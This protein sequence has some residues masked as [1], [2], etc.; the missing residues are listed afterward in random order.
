[1]PEAETKGRL[2]ENILYFCA[3]LR[4]AGIKVGTAQV[5]DCIKAVE[6]VGF[7]SRTDF[8]FTLRACLITRPDQLVLFQQVFTMFWRDPEFLERMMTSMLP[9]LQVETIDRPPPPGETRA[10]EALLPDP[11]PQRA[12]K[13]TGALEIEAQFSFSATERLKQMDFEQMTRA[14]AQEAKKAIA[15]MRLPLPN[16]TGRRFLVA[17]YGRKI[18]PRAA[19]RRARRTGGEVLHLPRQT[20]RPKRPDLVVLCDISGSMS[21]YSRMMMHFLHTLA[22]HQDAGWARLHAFTFGTRL[23]NISRYLGGK[24]P[25][26]AL[27]EIGHQVRDWDGGTHIGGSLAAFNKV[28]SRRVLGSGATVLLV[29]DGLERGDTEFLAAQCERLHLSCRRLIWLNPLLRYDKFAP[30]AGGIRAM[31][32]HVDRFISCHNLA[33]LGELA[34]VLSGNDQSSRAKEA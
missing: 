31:L 16:L 4:R 21:A 25:D 3:A 34:E 5:Q 30:Q 14:E 8:F 29:S 12:E 28:W 18:D 22:S 10:E 33:S 9:L 1:M 27:A 2:A 26:V 17:S 11:L 24:D 23:S 7:T 19:F 15:N 13:E 6:T 20:P 32:P